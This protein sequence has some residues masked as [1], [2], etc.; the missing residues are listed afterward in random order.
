[1]KTMVHN[2]RIVE[3][4]G[5]SDDGFVVEVGVVNVLKYFFK[6]CFREHLVNNFMLQRFARQFIKLTILLFDLL[7][8][9]RHNWICLSQQLRTKITATRTFLMQFQLF[10]FGAQ[11]LHL[12]ILVTDFLTGTAPFNMLLDLCAPIRTILIHAI[13]IH[14]SSFS[15]LW[16]VLR[17]ARL[18]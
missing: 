16:V 5:E 17:R 10:E 14:T 8:H 3:K 11:S 9:R 4:G 15:V 12:I 13:R 6:Y 18:L 7:K 1:M 2:G